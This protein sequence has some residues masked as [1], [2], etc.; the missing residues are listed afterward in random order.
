MRQPGS[1]AWSGE[2]KGVGMAYAIWTGVFILNVREFGL[3]S[4]RRRMRM[5][6]GRGIEA[7]KAQIRSGLLRGSYFGCDGP[8]RLKLNALRGTRAF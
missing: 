3:A 6:C 7:R 4:S 2:E 8:S 1:V 5:L